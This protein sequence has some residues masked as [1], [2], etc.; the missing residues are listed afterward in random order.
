[1]LVSL[2]VG[3]GRAAAQGVGVGIKGGFDF[4]DFRLENFQLDNRTGWQAGIFFGGNRTRTVGVQ[5][6]INWLRTET[7]VALVPAGTAR[8]QLDYIQVPILLRL[9]AGTQSKNGFALY[10]IAGP[11]FD[12]QVHESISGIAVASDDNFEN[13]NLSLML[14]GGMEI[15]RLVLEGRYAFGLRQINRDFQSTSELK[16]NSFAMLVGL[17]FN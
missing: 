1:M 2:L 12:M 8:V 5:G 16:V 17:R 7:D 6:E 3:S 11:S 9:N 10:G 14:G 13:F 4:P 15:S